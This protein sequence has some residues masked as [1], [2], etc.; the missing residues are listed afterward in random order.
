M[1]IDAGTETYMQ[2]NTDMHTQTQAHTGGHVHIHIGIVDFWSIKL[3]ELCHG[4]IM[5]TV[6]G[7]HM[8]IA[9]KRN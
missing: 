2:K 1:N 5:S 9:V 7:K 8:H 4:K 6:R 3:H